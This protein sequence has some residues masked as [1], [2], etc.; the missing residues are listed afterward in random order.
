MAIRFRETLR[1]LRREAGM[2]Q[3]E[4]AA[5]IYVCS[6]TLS[7]WERGDAEPP[8]WALERIAKLFGILPGDLLN[9]IG[10]GIK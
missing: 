9:G 8:F 7:A 3:K 2:T 5:Q 6:S 4:L 1:W 10:E